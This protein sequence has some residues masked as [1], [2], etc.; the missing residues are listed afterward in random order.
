M[1]LRVLS[2]GMCFL[3][4]DKDG[5]RGIED[6]LVRRWQQLGGQ[7]FHVTPKVRE[8]LAHMVPGSVQV[9]AE[10]QV[11]LGALRCEINIRNIGHARL[12]HFHDKC[13]SPTTDVELASLRS[14][15]GDIHHHQSQ[16]LPRSGVRHHVA[17][18]RNIADHGI[19]ESRRG[20]R[21]ELAILDGAR[22]EHDPMVGRLHAEDEHRFVLV[23]SGGIGLQNSY[24]AAAC[25]EE[26]KQEQE[27]WD[28]E[29][30]PGN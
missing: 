3:S 8:I 13:A 15:L 14:R 4:V 26:A 24:A 30:R 27:T 12:G 19:H 25:Q 16:L 1:P 28:S 23:R 17:A 18:P 7:N 29:F 2:N 21:L 20:G 11:E 9:G 6:T 22:K 5:A 10:P